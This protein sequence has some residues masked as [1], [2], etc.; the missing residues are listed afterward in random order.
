MQGTAG[1]MFPMFQTCF[2]SSFFGIKRLMDRP[3]VVGSASGVFSSVLLALVKDLASS[4][5]PRFEPVVT[6]CL[7]SVST[8]SFEEA[9]WG[10]FAAG[11]LVGL[12]IW[13]CLDLVWILRAKWR[14]F[15]W[16][17]LGGF[18]TATFQRPLHKVLA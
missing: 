6:S 8:F 13:P 11:V 18:Q 9:H 16:R 7:E 5:E 4:S 12:F 3:L 10:F 1:N 15:V 17:N 14:R 2:G